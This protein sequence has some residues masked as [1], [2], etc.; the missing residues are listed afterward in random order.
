MWP[1][2]TREKVLAKVNTYSQIGTN[3]ASLLPLLIYLLICKMIVIPRIYSER[4]NI[5][6]LCLR[7]QGLNTDSQLYFLE[8][9]LIVNV[10]ESQQS[11]SFSIEIGTHSVENS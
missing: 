2:L 4:A 3:T 1:N 5:S 9:I 11:I 10:E 8:Y 6:T 7:I